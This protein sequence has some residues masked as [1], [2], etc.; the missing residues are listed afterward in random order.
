MQRHLY[1][2]VVTAGRDPA[3]RLPSDVLVGDDALCDEVVEIVLRVVLRQPLLRLP[4]EHQAV[5]TVPRGAAI[6]AVAK[7]A[8]DLHPL[9]ST[10]LNQ[11][12]EVAVFLDVPSAR[13]LDDI[14]LAMAY[15]P[16]RRLYHSCRSRA[17]QAGAHWALSKA[18]GRAL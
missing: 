7:V 18:L 5:V 9:V 8:G 15:L 11:M 13:D 16:D 4:E 14:K 6:T 1:V 3:E 17:R 2:H 12:H 10:A